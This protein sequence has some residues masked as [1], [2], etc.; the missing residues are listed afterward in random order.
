MNTCKR[1][2]HLV[3]AVWSHPPRCRHILAAPI[4]LAS[5]KTRGERR[6]KGAATARTPPRLRCGAVEGIRRGRPSSWR[7]AQG[8]AAHLHTRPTPLCT[9]SRPISFRLAPRARGCLR[10]RGSSEDAGARVSLLSRVPTSRAA[11]GGSAGVH[12][13]TVPADFVGRRACT[14]RE[15]KAAAMSYHRS[16]GSFFCPT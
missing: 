8:L 5:P 14:R 16:C 13:T 4:L 1:C 7:A 9:Q 10:T 2:E 15:R 3:Y 12:L 11:E 6:C